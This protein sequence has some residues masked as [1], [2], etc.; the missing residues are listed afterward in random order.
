MRRL[1]SIFDVALLALVLA[2]PALAQPAR[3][4]TLIVSVRDQSG[5]VIVGARVVASQEGSPVPVQEG[6]AASD[7]RVALVDLAP[8]I[9]TLR[10]S[11]PGFEPRTLENVRVRAGENQRTMTLALE[12]RI[13]DVTVGRD[14]QERALDP[15]GDAFS[16]LLTREQIDALPDD[17]DELE[18]VLKAMSPPGATIRVDGFS[19]GRLPPKSQIR[20]I[21][22]PRIDQ[23][24][25]EAHGG[26]NGS[27]NIDI[28]TQPGGGVLG[29]SIETAIRDDALNAKNPFVPIKGEETLR[30]G[31]LSLSGPVVSGR[32]SF[33]LDF[34][35][36][37]Q[38]D[39]LPLVATGPE[40]GSPS[41][42]SA[43]S[44]HSTFGA[45][46]DQAL[47][48]SHMIR[49]SV[50]GVGVEENGLGVGGFDLP[51]RAYR[52]TSRE[53]T[54]RVAENGPLGRR[55]FLDARVEAQW[56]S[57]RVESA[58]ARPTVRVLDAF[59]TGGAGRAGGRRSVE[60][61]GAVDVDYVR[62]AHSMRAGLLVEGGRFRSDERTND[63]GTFTF[64]S[65]AD[66]Q[67][68][69]AS[70]FTRR[71]GDPLISYRS[72]Q[73]GAYFQDDYRLS[74]SLLLG[75]GIRYEGQSLTHQWSEVVPR[76][77]LSW[78]PF[79]SGKTTIRG[80]WGAFRDWIASTAFEQAMRIDGYRQR[81]TVINEP[82]FPAAD[83]DGFSEP[84]ARY[85]LDLA[86]PL[87]RTRSWY[88]GVDQS[89]AGFVRVGVNYSERSTSRLL[90]GVNENPLVNGARL[91]S[92]FRE[93]VRAI[94][95]ASQRGRSVHVN[96]TFARPEWKRVFAGF[97][98]SL[99]SVRSNTGGAFVL[100]ASSR[101]DTEWGPVAPRHRIGFNAS[102]RPVARLSIGVTARAQ[103]GFPY[104]VTTG[105]DSNGDG[106]FTERP[107]Q[108]PVGS[109][110]TAAHWEIGGRLSYAV[111]FG[112]PARRGSSGGDSVVIRLGSGGSGLEGGFD[113]GAEGSRY[114]LEFYAT[115][116]N[117]TNHANYIG[118][119]GVL[120]SPFFGQPTNVMNPR[121]AEIGI[122]F[123]F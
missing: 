24:A 25:A 16:T 41:V 73:L 37:H 113:G 12:K 84:P 98:Y 45:R 18:A 67:A 114:R 96:V 38:R 10:A 49:A 72:L 51:E 55:L 33:S 86:T 76:L 61:E 103:S 29:G 6:L 20:S 93:V 90:R 75:Y 63:L 109:A 83:G 74:R 88:A 104:T 52:S 15:G 64:S 35:G 14:G 111:G 11:F 95:D 8:A 112:G 39:E 21:R 102:M 19:G 121:K 118:Y 32:S 3:S 13:E 82:S 34:G 50:R 123:G 56:R 58:T 119:S 53:T 70:L 43:R 100:P 99:S 65:L 62:G 48:A 77:T 1:Q 17:P 66:Y 117:L 22:L 87:P 120:T 80:G 108:V 31:S 36:G 2:T 60:L 97:N 40:G 122:R 54:V 4:G 23:F 94:A 28:S 107:E 115:A 101:L 105:I 91:D 89:I 42:S 79:R 26:M 106:Q 110:R 81:E 59:V 5:G 46:F 47:G 9:Y 44:G 30:H 68:G 57:S 92:D 116:Q 7:G 71:S 27:L 78:A 69:R 85:V